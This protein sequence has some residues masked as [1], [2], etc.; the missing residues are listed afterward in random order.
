M[1]FQAEFSTIACGVTGVNGVTN[2][3]RCEILQR[4][5]LAIMWSGQHKPLYLVTPKYPLKNS[6]LCYVVDLLNK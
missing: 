5:D 2:F 6:S 4:I 1:N 3:L